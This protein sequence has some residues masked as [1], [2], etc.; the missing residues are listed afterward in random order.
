MTYTPQ[1]PSTTE[2]ERGQGNPEEIRRH[3]RLPLGGSS[4]L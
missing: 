4:Y 2:W 1:R 3:F